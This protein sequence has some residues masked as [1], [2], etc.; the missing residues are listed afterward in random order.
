M[1]D[2]PPSDKVATEPEAPAPDDTLSAGMGPA[3]EDVRCML[4]RYECSLPEYFDGH[5]VRQLVR[6]RKA[7]PMLAPHPDDTT[8]VE[9]DSS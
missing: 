5:R 4:E 3:P 8:D 2:L 1:H 9:R 7:W 6:A